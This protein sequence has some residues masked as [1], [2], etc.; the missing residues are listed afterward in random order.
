MM[1]SLKMRLFVGLLLPAIATLLAVPVLDH[2]QFT[3]FGMPA[4]LNWFFLWYILT[5]GC[6]AACWFLH[7]RHAPERPVVRAS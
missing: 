6:L 2:V 1:S 7:D 5:S 3:L 4:V